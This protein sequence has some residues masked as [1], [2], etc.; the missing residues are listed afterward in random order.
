MIGS[1]GRGG[2]LFVCFFSEKR[3]VVISLGESDE[4]NASLY[5]DE[6]YED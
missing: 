1:N 6:E 4:E 5:T 3:V 2:R